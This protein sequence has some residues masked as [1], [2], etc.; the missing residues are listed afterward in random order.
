M[1]LNVPTKMLIGGTAQLWEGRL[2]RHGVKT[3]AHWRKASISESKMGT[4]SKYP[5]PGSVLHVLNHSPSVSVY[6]PDTPV[7]CTL[8]QRTMLEGSGGQ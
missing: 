8:S 6:Q 2:G 3:K 7:V 1:F 4:R 5:Q